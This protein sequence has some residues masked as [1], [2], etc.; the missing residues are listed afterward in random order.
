M[1]GLHKKIGAMALAGMMALGG[2]ASSGLIVNANQISSNKVASNV[3]INNFIEKRGFKIYRKVSS[4]EEMSNEIRDILN[5]IKKNKRIDERLINRLRMLEDSHS[6]EVKSI[7][8]IKRLSESDKQIHRIKAGKWHYLLR[9]DEVGFY[10]ASAESGHRSFYSEDNQR[11]Y[12]V[13]K[14]YSQHSKRY[15]FDIIDVVDIESSP[16]LRVFE[17][18]IRSNKMF[19]ENIK[20]KLLGEPEVY[21]EDVEAL[22]IKLKSGANI[23]EERKGYFRAR[24]NNLDYIIHIQ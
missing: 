7:E 22:R 5:V 21:F 1:K 4:E 11:N 6:E 16:Q 9:I 13:M 19:A 18:K 10:S 12:D 3:N 20:E 8:D 23:F 14:Y 24:V 2:V 17:A 15:K